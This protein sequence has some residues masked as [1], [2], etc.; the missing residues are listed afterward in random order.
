MAANLAALLQILEL[1]EAGR[2]AT[3]QEQQ[4]LARWGGWGAFGQLFDTDE[5]LAEHAIL[6]ERLSEQ[7]YTAARRSTI[8]AH[9]TDAALVTPIWTALRELGFDGGDVLEPGCGPGHFIGLAPPEARMSGVELEPISAAIAA[10]LYP[11]AVITSGS[12]ADAA[13]PENTFDATIGNVPFAKVKLHDPRHN[14][15]R[16]HS[17]H[18]HFI[19]K[20]LRL[21]RPGGMVALLTSRYTM[22]AQNPGARAE[23]AQL[24][25]LVGAVRLPSDAHQRAA[26][27]HVVTDL[28]I[29][30]RRAPDTD[31]V[32]D[33]GTWDLALPTALGEDGAA[34]PL[35]NRYFRDHPEHVLGE[36]A[37]DRGQFD[38][39]DL[40][41]RGDLD[42]LPEQFATALAGIV[43]HAK[44]RG[45]AF[46]P[47]SETIAGP[48]TG[49]ILADPDAARFEG[50]ITAHPDGSFTRRVMGEQRPFA[51][52]AT[53]ADELRALIGLRDTAMALI[54]AEGT[55]VDGDP[56]LEQ[57]R[58]RLNAGYDDYVAEYGFIN[59]CSVRRAMRQGWHVFGEWC[60]SNGYDKVPA[61]RSAVV[62]YLE[63]LR[64]SGV[65]QDLLGKHLD[66]IDRN[67]QATFERHAKK[68]AKTIVEEL[69]RKGKVEA[70]D[71]EA[72][73]Q[74]AIER[75]SPAAL[76]KHAKTPDPR[77]DPQVLA[78]GSAVVATAPETTPAELDLDELGLRTTQI[79]RPPQ[80]G[81]RSDPFHTRATFLERYTPGADTAAKADILTRRQVN[82]DAPR[83]GAD[84]PEEALSIC[85]DT[86]SRVDLD[87]IARL[88]GMPEPRQARQALGRLVFDDPQTGELVWAPL[89]LSGNVRAKLA[90][91]QAAAEDNPAFAMNVEALQQVVPEDLGPRDIEVR[92]GSWIGPD[93]VQQFLRELLSDEHITVEYAVGIWLVQEHKA[94]WSPKT[95][96][97]AET[98]WS[99]GGLDAIELTEALL[100][101]A[102]IRVY[103][104]LKDGGQVFNPE[105]TEQATDK[106]AEL[107]QRFADWVWEDAARAR[108]LMRAYNDAFNSE[109]PPDFAGV[110]MALPGLSQHFT[111]REHQR[112]AVA[113]IIHQPGVGIVHEVG[114]GKTL[115]VIVGLMESRRRGLITKPCVVVPNDSI[116]ASF[117]EHWMLAY[118]NANVLIGTSDKLADDKKKDKNGRLDFVGQIAANEFDAIIMTKESFQRIPAPPEAE[119]RFL[120]AELDDLQNEL[121]SKAD[122]FSKSMTKKIETAVANAA[123]ALEAR[124][125]NIDRDVAGM[126]L[127][128]A[129][130]DKLAIDEAQN[131]KNG[132]VLSRIP[133]LVIPGAA[134][135][136]DLDVK[137]AWLQETYGTARV[138]L[139]SAYPWT[140][141]FSELYLWQRRLGQQLPRF[142][143]HARTFVVSEQYLEY[144]PGGTMRAK[145]R[146]RKPINQTELWRAI[147][148]LSDIRMHEDLNL[149]VPD[150]RGGETEIIE[151]PA[152]PEARVLTLD[153]ARRERRLQGL[154]WR[155]SKGE[156]NHLA[157]QHDARL[158]SLDLRTVGVRTQAPQKVHALADDIVTEWTVARDRIY[159]RP[160]G[161]EHPVRGGVIMVFC[162]L[163][164]PDARRWSFYTE[165]RTQLAARGMPEQGIRFI[166]EGASSPQ[167]KADILQMA[168]EGGVSVLVGSTMMMGAGINA[169]ARAIGG[170]L[171]TLSWRADIVVQAKGRIV[172]QGNQNP[173][174]FW[175][176]VLLSPSQD[177]KMAEISAQKGG[178]FAPFYSNTPPARTREIVYDDVETLT[179]MMATATGDPRYVRKA[180]LDKEVKALRRRASTHTR[181]RQDLRFTILTQ[182]ERISYLQQEAEQQ[183]RIAAALPDL[184]G[185]RFTMTVDGRPFTKRT[186]AAE[187]MRSVLA[188]GY[189]AAKAS[190]EDSRIQI[191]TI[192]ELEVHADFVWHGPSIMVA[193]GG[194]L[195][196]QYWYSVN[197]DELPG[198]IGLV[199]RLENQIKD[200]AE[201]G[202]RS[203]KAIRDAREVIAHAE[204]EVAKPFPDAELLAQREE[205]R[206]ALIAELMPQEAARP[207]ADEDPDSPEA[208]ARR[209]RHEALQRQYREVFDRADASA[210]AA[211]L[212]KD[213]A[214]NFRSWYTALGEGLPPGSYPP[215]DVALRVWQ[216]IGSPSKS[217]RFKLRALGPGEERIEHSAAELLGDVDDLGR[218]HDAAADE[219]LDLGLEDDEPATSAT[220]DR[221]APAPRPAPAEPGENSRESRYTTRARVAAAD[222]LAALRAQLIKLPDSAPDAVVDAFANAELLHQI[223]EAAL[224]AVDDR[225]MSPGPDGRMPVPVD[226]PP[227][228]VLGEFAVSCLSGQQRGPLIWQALRIGFL[229]END[230]LFATIAPAT[231]VP[232][233]GEV[234]V[235]LAQEWATDPGQHHKIADAIAK[236]V[237]TAPDRSAVQRRRVRRLLSQPPRNHT[238]ARPAP[239]T[240][241]EP[242]TT[243]RT[244]APAPAATPR[245]SP[246]APHVQPPRPAAENLAD[247][248]P[249]ALPAQPAAAPAPEPQP[250]HR[251]DTS[252]AVS[253]DLEERLHAARREMKAALNEV[254]YDLHR[255]DGRTAAG[256]NR[257][258]RTVTSNS[259]LPL[260]DEM[261]ELAD[262]V[263]EIRME[264]ELAAAG[265]AR[266]ERPAATDAGVDHAQR[267][268]TTDTT[269]SRSEQLAAL[270]QMVTEVRAH[271]HQLLRAAHE[272]QIAASYVETVDAATAEHVRELLSHAGR[273]DALA[274]RVARASRDEHDL[275]IPRPGGVMSRLLNDYDRPSTL[276][277]F[278][279]AAQ[280]GRKPA[281]VLRGAF[282]PANYLTW[283]GTKIWFDRGDEGVQVNVIA[284]DV[285]TLSMET[286]AVPD[287]VLAAGDG[288]ALV[289]MLRDAYD[290]A[291]A[292]A[293][294]ARQQALALLAGE[295]ES[296]PLPPTAAAAEHADA[297]AELGA[298]P[299]VE[300]VTRDAAEYQRLRAVAARRRTRA[301]NLDREASGLQRNTSAPPAPPAGS[302]QDRPASE[303]APGDVVLVMGQLRVVATTSTWTT[304]YTTKVGRKNRTFVEDLFRLEFTDGLAHTIWR[305]ET[306]VPVRLAGD[307]DTPGVRLDPGMGRFT[308][309]PTS[310]RTGGWD[311]ITLLPQDHQQD[312]P[313]RPV[314]AGTAV[315]F[316]PP[317]GE[318]YD[319]RA[320]AGQA[321]GEVVKVSGRDTLGH[322]DWVY[323]H[324][325]QCSDGTYD[326]VDLNADSVEIEATEQRVI[327]VLTEWA[328]APVRSAADGAPALE[329]SRPALVLADPPPVTIAQLEPL[330]ATEG[331][332]RDHHATKPSGGY[333]DGRTK[334][335]LPLKFDMVFRRHGTDGAEGFGVT[336]AASGQVIAARYR[337]NLIDLTNPL[338]KNPSMEEVLAAAR[339]PSARSEAEPPMPQEAKA[340]APK[341]TTSIVRLSLPEQLRAWG[342]ETGHRVEVS[343][344]TVAGGAQLVYQ[345]DGQRLQAHHLREVMDTG[346]LT[347]PPKPAAADLDASVAGEALAAVPQ[348]TTRGERRSGASTSL[349]ELRALAEKFDLETRVVRVGESAFVTIHH[350]DV[351]TP[352]VLSWP[353]GQPDIF[354]GAGRALPAASAHDYL[355]TYRNYVP[356]ALLADP[357]VEDWPRRIAQ[358]A[359]HLVPGSLEGHQAIRNHITAAAARAADDRAAAEHE[360]RKAEAI[361]GPLMLS[362]E[363]RAQ[364]V[365]MIDDFASGY[366]F[367]RRD[368][369]RYLVA[370]GHLD[371][372]IAEWEWINAYVRANPGVLDGQPDREGVQ[373][374]DLADHAAGVRQA[375]EFSR[376]AA[377]VFKAGDTDGALEL[378]DQAE[379]ADPALIWR[380]D[381]IRRRVR[382][383]VAAPA[384][385]FGASADTTEPSAAEV[386]ADASA[387]TTAGEEAG[388]QVSTPQ[389]Q[390][391]ALHARIN[392]AAAAWFSEQFDRVPAAQEYL[393]ERLGSAAAVERVRARLTVG[394]APNTRTGLVT[395]LREQGFADVDLEAA[396]VARDDSHGRCVDV[397]THRIM[398]AYRDIEGRVAGFVGRDIRPGDPRLKYLNTKTT[399]LFDKGKL[400]L[401]LHEQRELLRTGD[402]LV[403]E[404]PLD[405]AAHIA[406]AA[407]GTDTVALAACGSAVTSAHLDTIDALVPV[408]RR[409]VFGLDPDAGG[410]R[411]I[412]PRG[413][414]AA[415]RYPN[416]EITMLPSGLDPAEYALA[417]GGQAL[418]EAYRGAPFTRPALDVLIELRLQAWTDRLAFVEGQTGAARD[419]A[420]LL[421]GADLRRVADIALREAGKLGLDPEH[422]ADAV[423]TQWSA[424]NT[425]THRR[426]D[427]EVDEIAALLAIVD[428]DRV[429]ELA[430]RAAAMLERS[431]ELLADRIAQARNARLAKHARPALDS[432]PPRS[433]EPATGTTRDAV[434]PSVAGVDASAAGKTAAEPAPPGQWT[435]RIQVTVTA[436]SAIV[437]GTRGRGKDP[438]ILPKTLKANGFEWSRDQNHWHYV[439]R[440]KKTTRDDAVAAIQAV[441]S[442]LDKSETRPAPTKFPPTPQQQAAIDAATRGQDIAMLALAGSGK[443]TV[444]RMI[445]EQMPDK[446]ILYIAFNKSIAEEAKQSFGRN[447]TAR[448]FHALARAGLAHDPR[449]TEK[450]KRIAKG[451]D[452]FPEQIARTLGRNPD[453]D[454]TYGPYTADDPGYSTVA[455][456]VRDALAAV[457]AYRQS[458]DR[459]LSDRHLR[460]GDSASSRQSALVLGLARE[461]WADKVHPKGRLAWVHDDYR[462]IW[463]LG[464][465]RLDADVILFDEAQDINEL[466]AHL[467]QAQNA[468]KIVVG[469]TFQHIYGFTGARDYLTGWPADAVLPLTQ[470]WRF[471]PDVAE[472]GNKFLRLLEAPMELEG[473]P[474]IASVIGE[475]ESPDA[476]LCR[477]NAGTVANVIKGIEAGLRVALVG[478]GDDIKAIAK[479]AR[480]LMQGRRTTHEDLSAFTSWT[481]VCDYVRA[482]P[483][484]TT[485]ATLVALINE[486]GPDGLIEMADELVDEALTGEFGP[487]LTVSTAHKAKGREWPKVR[488]GTDFRGPSVDQETGELVLPDRDSLHLSYVAVTRAR[489]QL[490]PGSLSWILTFDQPALQPGV[491]AA[492]ELAAAPSTSAEASMA[493]PPALVTASPEPEPVAESPAPARTRAVPSG[494]GIDDIRD[495]ESLIRYI[496]AGS[497]DKHIRDL[498]AH[499]LSGRFRGDVA[500]QKAADELAALDVDIHQRVITAVVGR[501]KR[502]EGWDFRRVQ[503]ALR[504]LADGDVT[505]PI[506]SVGQY[507]ELSIMDDQPLDADGWTPVPKGREPVRGIVSEIQPQQGRTVLVL[508]DRDVISA[509]GAP[510]AVDTYPI[511]GTLTVLPLT[512][513]P[514]AAEREAAHLAR[515]PQIDAHLAALG[516]PLPSGAA[517]PAP[518]A[519]DPV[520]PDPAVADSVTAPQHADDRPVLPAPAEEITMD[521]PLAGPLPPLEMTE[522]ELLEGLQF[523]QVTDVEQLR[524]KALDDRFS[525]HL[526]ITAEDR[527]DHWLLSGDERGTHGFQER[528]VPKNWWFDEAHGDFYPPSDGQRLRAAWLEKARE[529][530]A[531]GFHLATKQTFAP[532][533][534]QLPLNT[535]AVLGR[536]PLPDRLEQA[537]RRIAGARIPAT[538]D[539]SGHPVVAHV[540]DTVARAE[541]AT[542]EDKPPSWVRTAAAVAA[543]CDYLPVPGRLVDLALAL[544][545]DGDIDQRMPRELDL[546]TPHDWPHW[547][548]AVRQT[549]RIL[550]HTGLALAPL[551]DRLRAAGNLFVGRVMALRERSAMT[552][553]RTGLVS[554]PLLPA[555]HPDALPL[556]TE[557]TV[558]TSQFSRA[559]DSHALG[560]GS[561]ALW[562]LKAILTRPA[563]TPADEKRVIEQE[564]RL[565]VAEIG[566]DF[567]ELAPRLRELGYTQPVGA[568]PVPLP[569]F[570]Q[571]IADQLL[572]EYG[573]PTGNRSFGAVP[574]SELTPLQRLQKRADA[575]RAYADELAA[576]IR[577]SLT[578]IREEADS[579]FARATDPQPYRGR[580]RAPFQAA[581]D[582][583][584]AGDVGNARRHLATALTIG[585]RDS[586]STG[587]HTARSILQR[588]LRRDIYGDQIPDSAW[589]VRAQLISDKPTFGP[590]SV[591]VSLSAWAGYL[592]TR[593]GRP[594]DAV[595]GLL[596]GIRVGEV[597]AELDAIATG[598][599]HRHDFALPQ[600]RTSPAAE[601]NLTLFDTATVTDAATVAPPPPSPQV[602]AVPVAHANLGTA[603]PPLQPESAAG[604]SFPM[605][606]SPAD[607]VNRDALLHRISSTL[608]A[609]PAEIDGTA[610]GPVLLALAVIGSTVARGKAFL[611]RTIALRVTGNYA[612]PEVIAERICQFADLLDASLPEP[613]QQREVFG[614]YPQ[615]R[616]LS[617]HLYAIAGEIADIAATPAELTRARAATWFGT[618]TEADVRSLLG[619]LA[620]NNHTSL[621]AYF[622]PQSPRGHLIDPAALALLRDVVAAHAR[623]ESAAHV[624]SGPDSA[625][626][627]AEAALTTALQVHALAAEARLRVQQPDGVGRLLHRAGWNAVADQLESAA[628]A[629]AA[630][631]DFALPG[632][633]VEDLPDAPEPRQ[634]DDAAADAAA[635]R[636]GKVV[637]YDVA[638]VLRTMS[639]TDVAELLRKA[640][641]PHPSP[642]PTRGQWERTRGAH[643][644]D[645]GVSERVRYTLKALQLD[646]AAD[647][648]RYG[649]LPWG[650]LQHWLEPGITPAR[651]RILLDAA[652]THDLLVARAGSFLAIDEHDL[653]EGLRAELGRYRD[654]ARTELVDAALETHEAQPGRRRRRGRHPVPTL[655]IEQL[656]DLTDRQRQLLERIAAI[657]ALI[658]A[659]SAPRPLMQL[660]AGDVVEHAEREFQPLRLTVDPVIE[661]EQVTLVGELLPPG[662]GAAAEWQIA[663]TA[664]QDVL[665]QLVPQA[666]SASNLAVPPVEQPVEAAVQERL[667]IP[668]DLVPDA[669]DWKR[670]QLRSD[671]DVLTENWVRDDTEL[672]LT[673]VSTPDTLLLAN[674]IRVGGSEH[675]LSSAD[676]LSTVLTEAGRVGYGRPDGTGG[677]AVTPAATVA[678]ARA[679]VAAN[680]SLR[681]LRRTP[682]TGWNLPG[683]ADA[684]IRRDAAEPA[685]APDTTAAST[686]APDDGQFSFWDV[687]AEDRLPTTP[688]P[689]GADA[690]LRTVGD[691]HPGQAASEPTALH[692]IPTDFDG[693]LSYIVAGHDVPATR[694]V[695]KVLLTGRGRGG[696]EVA[697]AASYLR[698][699]PPDV[700]RRAVTAAAGCT[701]SGFDIDRARA[702]LQRLAADD[703]ELPVASVGQ[704]VTVPAHDDQRTVTGQ[705]AG[706][707]LRETGVWLEIRDDEADPTMTQQVAVDA[708]AILTLV[709][710]NTYRSRTRPDAPATAAPRLAGSA[711]AE[712][713]AAA[714]EDSLPGAAE[715]DE[716]ARSDV[717]GDWAAELEDAFGAEIDPT[718][719]TLLAARE[720][721][722]AATPAQDGLFD[723]DDDISPEAPSGADRP[724]PGMYAP[725]GSPSVFPADLPGHDEPNPEAFTRA[726]DVAVAAKIAT[727]AR[728]GHDADSW[729]GLAD[730]VLTHPDPVARRTDGAASLHDA[731]SEWWLVQAARVFRDRHGFTLE[732]RAPARGA[733]RRPHD[734]EV[735]R[736]THR[737]VLDGS[738][739]VGTLAFNAMSRLAEFSVATDRDTSLHHTSP[740]RTPVAV[741]DE[742]VNQWLGLRPQPE[743][744]EHG[745]VFTHPDLFAQA[746]ALAREAAALGYRLGAPDV[747]DA[748]LPLNTR[749]L[750]A[751]LAEA[752]IRL[753]GLVIPITSDLRAHPVVEHIRTA[754]A[755]TAG[756][757]PKVS[758]VERAKRWA[759][760]AAM[761]VSTYLRLPHRADLVSLVEQMAPLRGP[762]EAVMPRWLDRLPVRSLPGFAETLRHAGRAIDTAEPELL[763]LTA[764]LRGVADVLDA[765]AAQWP[766]QHAATVA[767]RVG[768]AA[769]TLRPADQPGP[770]L[771]VQLERADRHP[772]VAG[773]RISSAQRDIVRTLTDP[774]PTPGEQAGRILGDGDLVDRDRLL[775]GQA[776]D[777]FAH[778]ADEAGYRGPLGDPPQPVPDYLR[779]VA[780]AVTPRPALPASVE[781]EHLLLR[782]GVPWASWSAEPPAARLQRRL[783]DSAVEATKQAKDAREALIRARGDA[784]MTLHAMSDPGSE[785]GGLVSHAI[786][787]ADAGDLTA[788]RAAVAEA[789]WAA[790]DE[791][792][793]APD[794]KLV[795]GM[796]TQ[797]LVRGIHSDQ[798]TDP[799]WLARAID[800]HT[801]GLG[802][803]QDVAAGL[804]A[805]AWSLRRAARDTDLLGRLLAR[806]GID[807]V[808]AAMDAVAAGLAR[809]Q[810]F[811]PV[812]DP[813][814]GKPRPDGPLVLADGRELSR[815][816]D[817]NHLPVSLR[818][819]LPGDVYLLLVPGRARLVVAAP[820]P[821]VAGRS[822]W[823]WAVQQLNAAD[824][825]GGVDRVHGVTYT[826]PG[827]AARYGAKAFDQL[828]A[829]LEK[830][831]PD[832]LASLNSHWATLTFVPKW[833]NFR[834]QL[835][836]QKLPTALQHRT[837]QLAL[838]ALTQ[839]GRDSHAAED[840]ARWLLTGGDGPPLTVLETDEVLGHVEE[841][842]TMARVYGRHRVT[843]LMRE[844]GGPKASSTLEQLH[845]A[846]RAQRLQPVDDPDTTSAAPATDEPH[847]RPA[848]NP[849]PAADNRPGDD[850][851]QEAPARAGHAPTSAAPDPPPPATPAV[852]PAAPRDEPVAGRVPQ[853]PDGREL[854]LISPPS[855]GRDTVRTFQ[856]VEP[857]RF[858]LTLLATPSDGEA[859][860]W[861][862]RL[863]HLD[864]GGRAAG[865]ALRESEEFG[866]PEHALADAEPALAALEAF[867][868][869]AES[870]TA[871]TVTGPFADVHFVPGWGSAIEQ[872]HRQQFPPHIAQALPRIVI[873]VAQG[874]NIP[875]P[876][877]VEA[878]AWALRGPGGRHRDPVQVRELIGYF[879]DLEQRIYDSGVSDE[880]PRAYQHESLRELLQL[881][882][883]DLAIA[884]G[885]APDDLTPIP[886]QDLLPWRAGLFA[887]AGLPDDFWPPLPHTD[888]PTPA[889][890]ATAASAAEVGPA[891]PPPRQQS[892]PAAATEPPPAA[893]PATPSPR[894]PS[895]AS[896]VPS[897][898][899]AAPARPAS[900]P[901]AATSGTGPGSPARPASTEPGR[902]PQG[903]SGLVPAGPGGDDPAPLREVFAQEWATLLDRAAE[904]GFT[905]QTRYAGGSE[906]DTRTG[907]I[908]ISFDQPPASR[909]VDLALH[910]VQAAAAATPINTSPAPAAARPRPESE[911][912]VH[913]GTLDLTARVPSPGPG[914]FTGHLDLPAH[915]PSPGRGRFTGQLD[916][917]ALATAE[918]PDGR[919]SSTVLSDQITRG[920]GAGAA[921]PPAR[922]AARPAP[923]PRWDRPHLTGA[924]TRP[925]PGTRSGP[926]R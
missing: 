12:F 272:R 772:L 769:I 376:Q 411:G 710:A 662:T 258:R 529:A 133:D 582:A 858:R 597:A 200:V 181:T 901:P 399:P 182:N 907:V 696:L 705:V 816:T 672:V 465:P 639:A 740:A 406:A 771:H 586:V 152:P 425:S 716:R 173:E 444:L 896:A 587:G 706:I 817:P 153:F 327:E 421:A 190:K 796:L 372:S 449:Y 165:L 735:D 875:A 778:V 176:A 391:R 567:A 222:E 205:E 756:T 349:R 53:Q 143:V 630:A 317:E 37:L 857:G 917:T 780:D 783:A 467:V 683:G 414:E 389:E 264:V 150:L 656:T 627:R 160:D 164:V 882:R 792:R 508:I 717:D 527:A 221:A 403:V 833:G 255:S 854:E 841:L 541:A 565:H 347:W 673:W 650:E 398:F 193:L 700:T 573:R 644:P 762:H 271:R 775:L 148:V 59:R 43:E 800:R 504:R 201:A 596:A 521:S 379:L 188:A 243:D 89:Y 423:L 314:A 135:S 22:D 179:E 328:A 687:L 634:Q 434:P 204:T 491:A 809:R 235:P 545:R 451:G 144:T 883:A 530:A 337:P 380:W 242:Q 723:V 682:E 803:A 304:Q 454:V 558:A 136:I 358:L 460:L 633:A 51:P 86:H 804:A 486:H 659:E 431:P 643:E 605:Q 915:A 479:A 574:G 561:P 78:A 834:E 482:H 267:T 115:E 684:G 350:P 878:A 286:L 734:I 895:T 651:L 232:P 177:A 71:S 213:S 921:T 270:G 607:L 569:E 291:A 72:A 370:P 888:A 36:F 404:G 228:S 608:H 24:A 654:E 11:D 342:D 889:E 750:K 463:A 27:T 392:A 196:R 664:P 547:A 208:I 33:F 580:Q 297:A 388:E 578:E 41:V 288:D 774:A 523:Y 442:E 619:A 752:R 815:T 419:I 302:W 532:G 818:G 338:L 436:D 603:E 359:P 473:N 215:P 340:P 103:D 438:Q 648:P 126:T 681:L 859:V 324:V 156:D 866:S 462:K 45:L 517:G 209:E 911:F 543:I 575:D 513:R 427:S 289:T 801:I 515:Q 253:A 100:D 9:Y 892:A 642:Y 284:L 310:T 60:A 102:P 909:V 913:T 40:I 459:E 259:A 899:R 510:R 477:T 355:D 277:G 763:W 748:A 66:S 768:L 828:L 441:L 65:G 554:I 600:A 707:R 424:H 553:S 920:R 123:A 702:A 386:P 475:V 445:A 237:N 118:P 592:R 84:T 839:L 88:L 172:R 481:K 251:Q 360:L 408:D 640:G 747:T 261:T 588:V 321:T 207:D 560:A 725:P 250:E 420:A 151:V 881:T 606:L 98:L 113:R 873:M 655:P 54:E 773:F 840:V 58:S 120:R 42:R 69:V 195:G 576:G 470:S 791:T 447:V 719:L 17:I 220:D 563:A 641:Q 542:W 227:A 435:R 457:T 361:A 466:Q 594:G 39:H 637:P 566:Q 124:L 741:T 401:G 114:A 336:A 44:A 494:A 534:D 409:R 323:R 488:I 925:Q 364:V 450:F 93:V 760:A 862:W 348:D 458:S 95:R 832:E 104:Q 97:A 861:T 824:F 686:S 572:T 731:G 678:T 813:K 647:A 919:A 432:E 452:G 352:P 548:G 21:T 732:V 187:A 109:I 722:G 516:A 616:V 528:A 855:T 161:T 294:A 549:A 502:G 757:R 373:E 405:Q 903:G 874:L 311:S 617:E 645:A 613:D 325:V 601:A 430:V 80:G 626:G 498:V 914:R 698:T 738:Q 552:Q 631:G 902:P 429:G 471:G 282:V 192:G 111:L 814:P 87:E 249:S 718:P 867:L 257:G 75:N 236:T 170:Y 94:K 918:P 492:A 158:A 632:T 428:R 368:V 295:P 923:A 238:G 81:F 713:A 728:G 851:P 536:T 163:S 453:D 668:E 46:G 665:V 688:V 764:R 382:G 32:V 581:V 393:I 478:G 90:I 531:L 278:A 680:T 283:R 407:A 437:T 147:Q 439:D 489:E 189:A 512:E 214:S 679:A 518:A 886:P 269:L 555:D 68:A 210:R 737:V 77:L 926:N 402:P 422:M 83:L 699:G 767:M 850:Q 5:F 183:D 743:D 568:P 905:V 893:A 720:P 318:D 468:Q 869:R 842:A 493:Q 598:L 730:L 829:A 377:A 499:V 849:D 509:Q 584:S 689:D 335:L 544:T 577:T 676:E 758:G 241:R 455:W 562:S 64:D 2:P 691:P 320:R 440:R 891:P 239:A 413:P 795:K 790:T 260:T 387:A 280:Q 755:D 203:R 830:S 394:Y 550:D 362:P 159:H 497:R 82:R 749:D 105:R 751:A 726:L 175:K 808:A 329:P 483:E 85:M 692:H 375:E 99:G 274:V 646:V 245:E 67:H 674:P 30:R 19:L 233:Q 865:P 96:L 412:L 826:D 879:A 537:A 622:G 736:S 186:D 727:M 614:I 761:A 845:T 351:P 29:L 315:V 31:P 212:D 714:A 149:P 685:D 602:A 739:P 802:S 721:N 292:R 333:R 180:E 265:Y 416:V 564:A 273:L 658:P 211:G 511:D 224:E 570:L 500:P 908:Y 912:P 623:D 25:D 47:R 784:D 281:D 724:E 789:V 371:G 23:M 312:L 73:I 290:T 169:Q 57:L 268:V 838:Q 378:L 365:R 6:R 301:R 709:P 171:V 334:G 390:T 400:L 615:Q 472:T 884:L 589:I 128:D 35:I 254:G 74:R 604:S 119:E 618:L 331:W 922:A 345:V 837:A 697:D 275:I 836:A 823:A 319:G 353:A 657:R 480:N 134:R 194:E 101:G 507:V 900:P 121:E 831:P 70:A 191:A 505:L 612:A 579:T 307:P 287:A 585:P 446:K 225:I 583:L 798:A 609:M 166:Q 356:A 885:L 216:D 344:E 526:G 496:L 703:P 711:A 395:H 383:G 28:L 599:A 140:G 229:L 4:V 299:D 590:E 593:S 621:D 226:D 766:D 108:T 539:L 122:T 708:D 256:I 807:D 557:V 266:L 263:D 246:P 591:A 487:Q 821:E 1:R 145:T 92:L 635:D 252:A 417:A 535:I 142:D 666:G 298:A 20:A 870:R 770:P 62:T 667:D 16:T 308:D 357:G 248:A 137:L 733:K 852:T 296:T 316:T 571:Q 464:N 410:T 805:W 79:D 501:G 793:W 753:D 322:P 219:G 367:D 14:P 712:P 396:G 514:S 343:S 835:L 916:L 742:Q 799:E 540:R 244:T 520:D 18:N 629:M 675:I 285:D 787:D 868:D 611:P 910:L 262:L 794:A 538:Q 595:G 131:Y 49:V 178:M 415:A 690:M 846:L 503:A 129:G 63:Q 154:G 887:D 397:F 474:A 625:A 138:I 812:P 786:A 863:Q 234:K 844:G 55:T 522:E 853:L 847:L 661:A 754:I 56:A 779:Q 10:A 519:P 848:P 354:D 130:I 38:A 652:D 198:G 663:T 894:G 776:I 827:T 107:N 782:A 339:I 695:V 341:V 139:A 223:A 247:G 924:G 418:I 309:A 898:R 495:R 433:G 694:E 461:I 906:V 490:D 701:H 904:L 485:L 117:H 876:D 551:A 155:P 860:D 162:D 167:K 729:L 141:K 112:I 822:P 819:R 313:I 369:G 346:R 745:A 276:L 788:A 524:L 843:D 856:R 871:D 533:R 765:R 185:D 385:N 199:T 660:N 125:A 127:A 448:T 559:L 715:Q 636:A 484:E 759:M 279:R 704:W 890:P 300:P 91:A 638:A 116:A 777:A 202:D 506:A 820:A 363:R 556:L 426:T 880:L 61:S 50:F 374:R 872:L 197:G 744:P 206:D 332:E 168:Q 649:R 305:P 326:W 864:R 384:P 293:D 240:A 218:N 781:H 366:V 620:E 157:I 146:T 476:I 669:F 456:L 132:F 306:P 610:T 184:A 26:G 3:A 48:A 653:A 877:H 217:Q 810:G 330:L 381:S 797:F 8:N 811:A 671:G 7:E 15:G 525:F 34:A 76:L 546:E 469:D 897:P 443:T 825:P 231:A 628:A 110:E 624:P 746:H 174:V 230:A 693:L 52:P 106:A 785:A 806:I 677:W 303:V 13:T 670:T